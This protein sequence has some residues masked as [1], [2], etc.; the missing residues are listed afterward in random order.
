ML[1]NLHA[2]VGFEGGAPCAK[3][4]HNEVTING[5]ALPQRVVEELRR[6]G[7]P[8]SWYTHHELED[9][10]LACAVDGQLIDDPNGTDFQDM[11]TLTE[12]EKHE[13]RAARAKCKRP[14]FL[15]NILDGEEDEDGCGKNM[16]GHF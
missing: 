10:V 12:D 4:V 14:Y 2:C 3:S 5:V 11:L 7:R 9:A 8:L 16:A 13:H 15:S 6:L 1:G